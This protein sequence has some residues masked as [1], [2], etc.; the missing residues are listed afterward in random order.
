MSRSGEPE[1]LEL[2]NL[3]IVCG[4]PQQPQTTSTRLT[5]VI[6]QFTPRNIKLLEHSENEPHL[7]SPCRRILL[8]ELFAPALRKK[9]ASGLRCWNAGIYPKR[10]ATFS[11]ASREVFCWRWM[12]SARRLFSAASLPSMKSTLSG[13]SCNKPANSLLNIRQ[14]SAATAC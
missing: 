8:L 2:H 9:A 11:N 3:S 10:F 13:S 6:V 1:R 4:C 12:S 7:L 5:C 14:I